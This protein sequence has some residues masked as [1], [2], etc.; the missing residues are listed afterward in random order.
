MPDAT[1]RRNVVFIISDQHQQAATGCYG[2]PLVQTPNID[3]LAEDGVRFTGAYCQSP[4]CAPSRASLITGTHCHTC[5]AYSGR[6]KT[7]IRDLPTMG[8]AFR[9][10]GYVTGS[11]GKVHVIGETRDDRDLGFSERGLRYYTYGKEDYIRAVGAENALKYSPTK[12]GR[13]QPRA[14][15]YNH[16]NLPVDLDEELTFDALVARRSVEFLEDHRDEPFFLWVGLEKPHPDWYAPKS[17]HDLYDPADVE[18]PETMREEQPGL[19]EISWKKLRQA[20]EYTDDDA[21]RCMAA[22]FAN[23]SYLDDNVGRVL[24][25]LDRLDLRRNTIVIYTSDHGELLLQHGLTQK[26][27]FYEPAV[28]VPLVIAGPDLPAD[29]TRGHIVG[30]IDLLPTMLDLNGLAAPDTLEGESLHDVLDGSAPTDGRRAFSEF[31]S[32]GASER[33]I[34]TPR[35][36]YVLSHGRGRQLY[37]EAADPLETSNL[38]DAPDLS[39]VR[40][41]LEARLLADWEPP[42]PDL[43]ARPDLE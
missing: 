34:R 19:P 6:I 42:D 30:L 29:E 21:R 32:F 16:E 12:L 8:T 4:L 38:A 14:D 27:C 1:D 10:A 26:H 15:W 11:F 25:A 33:M 39:E 28:A 24:A 35:W 40:D 43:I 17:F 9:D 2:H 22:Y 20:H 36:K 3:R 23:V 13:D 5:R 41:E 31:Y 18:L 37:D 7:P